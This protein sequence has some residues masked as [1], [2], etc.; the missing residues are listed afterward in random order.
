MIQ[1]C[2][3]SRDEMLIVD[4]D[5]VAYIQASGNYCKLMYI[6]GQ[7]LLISLGL[8]KIETLIR[9]INISS[10][11]NRYVRLGRSLI[12]NQRYL[13]R[14]SLTRQRLVLSDYSKNLHE[15]EVSKPVLKQYKEQ[16]SKSITAK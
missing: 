8:A 3:N 2:L 14:I 9:K 15:L 13:F 6:S 4:L 5:Q 10:T 12:I 7:S 11:P 16:L 1:L